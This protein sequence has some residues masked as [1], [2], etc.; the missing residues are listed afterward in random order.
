MINCGL[1]KAYVVLVNTKVHKTQSVNLGGLLS[2]KKY[3]RD[4]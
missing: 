2:N 3:A 4:I 1:R